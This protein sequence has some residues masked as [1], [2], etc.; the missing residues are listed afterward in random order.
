MLFQRLWCPST[1]TVNNHVFHYR[2]WE[3]KPAHIWPKV[4]LWELE[5]SQ[6]GWPGSDGESGRASNSQSC[7]TLTTQTL[8]LMTGSNNT[9]WKSGTKSSALCYYLPKQDKTKLITAIRERGGK[10]GREEVGG[11]QKDEEPENHD[12][13]HVKSSSQGFFMSLIM[14]VWHCISRVI[15]LSTELRLRNRHSLFKQHEEETSAP[16]LITSHHQPIS[17]CLKE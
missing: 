15:F 16:H 7:V 6:Q 3:G 12:S 1:A 10:R 14:R 9:H 5:R 8:C 4:K 13:Q 11:K 17:G 2:S